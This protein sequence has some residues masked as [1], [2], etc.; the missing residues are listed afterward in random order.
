MAFDAGAAVKALQAWYNPDTG[1]YRWSDPGVP[2][3]IQDLSAGFA[4][5]GSP[6]SGA[7]DLL[8]RYQE[9]EMW[10]VSANAIAS[11][12]DYMAITSDTSNIY[13]IANTFSQ[14]PA[15]FTVSQSSTEGGAAA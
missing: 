9:T 8:E 15:T 13:A 11:L 2:Q 3:S 14:A 12:I 5:L 4:S 1:L 6:F 7:S 10:W